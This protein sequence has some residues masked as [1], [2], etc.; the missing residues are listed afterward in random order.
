MKTFTEYLQQRDA[1]LN[2]INLFTK[3]GQM[4]GM[5]QK[6]KS[7]MEIEFSMLSQQ[8]GEDPNQWP[9]S[10]RYQFMR[11]YGSNLGSGNIPS[12]TSQSW[13]DSQVGQGYVAA[14]KGDPFPDRVYRNPRS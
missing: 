2:E 9:Q 8:H 4:L 5:G 13:Q 3:L 11:K 10:V 14:N 1:E 7:P 12:S 6:P